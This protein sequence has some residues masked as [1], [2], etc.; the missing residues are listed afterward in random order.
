MISKWLGLKAQAVTLRRHGTSIK[1]IEKRLGIP[2]STLSGWLRN[3]KLS[4]YHKDRLE[5]RWKNALVTA[6]KS[7]ILWH[8]LQKS[9]RLKRASEEGAVVLS[10]IKTQDPA[11]FEL[12]LAMLYLGEGM[13]QTPTTAVG[14]SNPLVLQF[15]VGGLRQLYNIPTENIRC[16][17]HLRADQNPD[18][19][20]RYWSRVL[21]LPISN[22][23]KPSV[24][25]R[26]KGSKTYSHYKGVCVVR[27]NRVAIQ[28]RLMYI[29]NNFC[30]QIVQ[31]KSTLSS[32]G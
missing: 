27:C 19:I 3:V 8:N 13:R 24:D 11:V 26:T 9:E 5:Q 18:G 20:K 4:K 10:K 15:F 1:D 12:A 17:I 23:G 22:F 30:M 28:R 16:E 32:V 31:K 6:R 14:N 2:R 25:V 29:A 7:A 21:G